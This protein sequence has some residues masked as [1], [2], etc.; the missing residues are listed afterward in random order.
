MPG[1]VLFVIG[2]FALDPDRTECPFQGAA[3]SAGQFRDG[4]DFCCATEQ[5][6]LPG[7]STLSRRG[8]F[9]S[10]RAQ[11]RHLSLSPRTSSARSFH[12]AFIVAI[13]AIIF[14]RDQSL[15]W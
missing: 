3:N 9:L 10:C 2:N 14:L 1:R 5:P 7:A 13:N 8:L 12:R 15:S 11:S 4:E 6:R